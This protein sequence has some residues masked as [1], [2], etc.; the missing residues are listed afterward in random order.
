VAP[1]RADRDLSW[2]HLRI[3]SIRRAPGKLKYVAGSESAM[4]AWVNDIPP[5]EAAR[6]LREV[7]LS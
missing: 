1:G 7:S 3:H 4:G 6:A 5:E 2:L